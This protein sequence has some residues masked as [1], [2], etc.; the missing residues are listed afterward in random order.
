PTLVAS[1]YGMNFRFMPELSWQLGYPFALG[2]MILSGLAP[3]VYFKSK[4]WL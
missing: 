3:Y 1:I 4:G 2:L